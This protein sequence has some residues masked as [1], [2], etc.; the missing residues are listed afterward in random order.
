MSEAYPEM[1]L[2]VPVLAPAHMS[3]VDYGTS[4]PAPAPKSAVDLDWL[5]HQ[6]RYLKTAT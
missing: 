6:N 5:Q 2:R 1:P 4:K 3:A